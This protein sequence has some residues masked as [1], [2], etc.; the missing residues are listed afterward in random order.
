[1]NNYE[2]HRVLIYGPF[3]D[4]ARVSSDWMLTHVE[5]HGT[6]AKDAVT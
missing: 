4:A 1:M 6:W 5:S 3:Y 2:L